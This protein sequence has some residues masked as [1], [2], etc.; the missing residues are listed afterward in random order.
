[1]QVSGGMNSQQ[2]PHLGCLHRVLEPLAFPVVGTRAQASWCWQMATQ[3]AD[4]RVT[5][6]CLYSLQPPR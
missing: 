3:G 1:M 2:S 6:G 5:K 4:W